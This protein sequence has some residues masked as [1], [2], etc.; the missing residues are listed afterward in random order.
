M[1]A[2]VVAQ[3]WRGGREARM[4]MMLAGCRIESLDAPLA[5]QTGMLC[6]WSGTSD[7][8]DA[9]VI[10][11]AANR[12]DDVLTSD[13]DDLERLASFEPHAGRILDIAKLRSP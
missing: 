11:C 3:V 4:A 7:V 9:F 12:R 13:P 10:V 1:P 5:K 8:V 6:G 2:P